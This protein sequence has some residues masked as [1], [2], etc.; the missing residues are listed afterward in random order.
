[1]A[2]RLTAIKIGVDQIRQMADNLGRLNAEGFSDVAVT[3]LNETIDRAYEM[4]RERITVGINLTD[5]Y[6]R[7]RMTVDHA[8]A[9][10]PEA[11]ITASGSRALMTRLA[12]YD[13]QMVIVPRKTNRASRSKGLLKIPAGGKQGGVNVTVVKGAAKTLQSGFLLNL[14]AGAAAGEKVGVFR[15]EG[16]KLKHLYGPSV[17]QL[18]AYQAPRISAEVAD[19]LQDTFLRRVDEQVERILG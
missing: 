3:V 11:A 17:Y 6:L 8:T 2:T 4:A 12:T 19:D 5:D 16:G 13:A 14:R 9:G 1:M 7:R 15:R 10:K 18:F